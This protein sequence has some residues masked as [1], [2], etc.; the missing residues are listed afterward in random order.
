MPDREEI[1]RL[2]QKELE[3]EAR[4]NVHRY[5]IEVDFTDSVVILEGEVGHPGAKKLA[6]EK[7]A[8]IPEVRGVVDRVR[9]TPTER[10]GDG[11]IRD[12]VCNH[13]LQEAEFRNCTVRARAKG[14]TETLREVS[15]DWGGDIEVDVEEGV[16]TLEGWVLSLSHKRAAGVLAWWTPGCR[17]V[18]NALEVRPPEEDNDNE[19]VDALKL[20]L[21]MDPLVQADQIHV[22]CRDYVVTLEGV[23]RT[24]EELRQAEFD[25]WCIFAVDDVVNRIEVIA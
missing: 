8:A 22:S 14:R 21:E 3:S 18:I 9:V 6:L 19:I 15:T 1:I 13:L 7:A 12:S 17:D 11:A 10:K 25:A 20:V 23:A 16:I 2:V 5:P 4:I 24:E